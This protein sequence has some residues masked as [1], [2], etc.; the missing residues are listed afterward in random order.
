M[1]KV[2]EASEFLR[3]HDVYGPDKFSS[4]LKLSR[5]SVYR[6][7]E[8]ARELV[9]GTARPRRGAGGP[10]SVYHIVHTTA[11]QMDSS[12][13]DPDSLADFIAARAEGRLLYSQARKAWYVF[14][15]H[16]F[17]E[18]KVPPYA[19][20]RREV[21]RLLHAHPMLPKSDRPDITLIVRLLA[22][23][24][25]NDALDR[26]THLLAFPNCVY[27]HAVRGVR[28]GAVTDGLT[29]AASFAYT[30]WHDLPQADRDR[31]M[32]WLR[33]IFPDPT[34]LD[35]VLWLLAYGL[36]GN[37]HRSFAIFLGPT[38]SGKTTLCSLLQ[39]AFGHLTCSLPEAVLAR[40][41]TFNPSAPAEFLV[42]LMSA[43]VCFVNELPHTAKINASLVKVV[44]SNGDA[45]SFKG[46]RGLQM[47]HVFRCFIV[48]TTN[49]MP[50]YDETDTALAD[51][52]RVVRFSQTLPK[53]PDYLVQRELDELAPLFA[54]LL[55]DEL[56]ESKLEPPQH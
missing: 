37:Q 7:R 44:T 53:R 52:L 1:S 23:R 48:M 2:I 47:N 35:Y 49:F 5:S 15:G 39:R 46:N 30:N 50:R 55:V 24:C 12:R 56:K 31:L 8:R 4:I 32:H 28:P 10:K 25:A 38:S 34:E 26:S 40:E 51:R 36:L 22:T 21:Q 14:E 18:D 33:S 16:S 6:L 45:V 11:N 42:P 19:R 17:A 29:R 54:S 27:D 41:R 43:R 3:L 13:A 20:V 9:A